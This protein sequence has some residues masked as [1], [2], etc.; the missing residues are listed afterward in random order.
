MIDVHIAHVGGIP[1]EETLGYL[2]PALLAASEWH[3]QTFAPASAGCA[4][5]PAPTPPAQDSGRAARTGRSKQG[6]G[7]TRAWPGRE[8]HTPA[9]SPSR[10]DSAEISQGEPLH[11]RS[12][13]MRASAPAPESRPPRTRLERQSCA[14][15]ALASPGQSGSAVALPLL[16]AGAVDQ[17]RSRDELRAR[18]RDGCSRA[19]GSRS[20][21]DGSSRWDSSDSSGGACALRAPTPP[22]SWSTATLPVRR[23]Q[24]SPR[25]PGSLSRRR[26][27]SP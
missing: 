26:V 8:D 13:R 1:I 6:T 9:R 21:S 18:Q 24:S 3:G 2:G 14:I 19:Q 17:S 27:A 23:V 25:P 5:T 10:R 16:V 15:Q 7:T 22:R 4:R 11:C 12:P 20:R